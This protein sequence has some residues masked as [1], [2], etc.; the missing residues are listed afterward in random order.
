MSGTLGGPEGGG[1]EMTGGP[2]IGA[3]GYN[4]CDGKAGR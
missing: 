3:P 1:A 2:G 4:A